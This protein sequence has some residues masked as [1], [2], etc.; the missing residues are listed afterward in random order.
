MSNL[1]YVKWEEVNRYIDTVAAYYK[2]AELS[3]VYGLPRGGLVFATMISHKLNIPMLLAPHTNCLIVD[4]VADSGESL[5]HYCYNS[6][7]K[8]AHNYHISTMFAKSQSSVIPELVFT[9]V[10]DDTWL[11][12][13]WEEY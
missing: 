12:F 13:P 4:D 3:G 2:N 11:V 6:S 5:I 7:G 9:T 1:K 10:T 8:A